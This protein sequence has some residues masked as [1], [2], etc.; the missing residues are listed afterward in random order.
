MTIEDV[1][2]VPGLPR[3]RA[4]LIERSKRLGSGGFSVVLKLSTR[5]VLK[6]TCCEAT[7][8]LFEVL[9]KQSVPRQTRK[10]LP[11]VFADWGVC[12]T[13]ND[14]M[15]Y[16][17]YVLERLFTMQDLGETLALPLN[18]VSSKTQDASKRLL[19]RLRAEKTLLGN[20]QRLHTRQEAFGWENAVEIA[21]AILDAQL[22]ETG[23]A[24][25]FLRDFCHCNKAELDLDTAGNILFGRDLRL[26]LADPVTMPIPMN[27]DKVRRTGDDERCSE[28]RRRRASH[29][30]KGSR[31]RPQA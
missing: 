14:G 28:P 7:Q 8:K 20:A 1:W 13:D 2:P 16:R 19:D 22:A 9:K 17:G 26:V 31:G 27:L 21:E 11:R 15:L 25:G 29:R 12:A 3:K 18:A 6:L 5:R 10:R 23:E 24:F 30:T 4:R